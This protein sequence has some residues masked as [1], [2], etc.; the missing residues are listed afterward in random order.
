MASWGISVGIQSSQKR[1]VLQ[2]SDAK[3]GREDLLNWQQK[4]LTWN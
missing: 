1:N 4:E 3:E 2:D